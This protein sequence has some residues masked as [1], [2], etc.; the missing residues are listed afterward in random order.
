MQLDTT[1]DG[2]G[3]NRR[4]GRRHEDFDPSSTDLL[5]RHDSFRTALLNGECDED[6][7]NM[8]PI[9]RLVQPAQIPDA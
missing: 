3:I 5:E 2:D 6:A 9:T 1:R 7:R 8:N 4:S